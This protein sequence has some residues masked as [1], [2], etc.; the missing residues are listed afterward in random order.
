MGNDEPIVAGKRVQEKEL[1][2]H[3]KKLNG[4][5]NT[6]KHIE[7]EQNWINRGSKRIETESAKAG[8]DA[9]ESQ[10]PERNFE[11]SLRG[12]QDTPRGLATRG[13]IDGQK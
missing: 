11:S 12:D 2:R 9:G 3:Q 10:S 13:R 5:K 1:E 7:A 6:A 8:G 4:P